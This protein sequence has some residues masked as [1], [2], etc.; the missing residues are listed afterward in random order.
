MAAKKA[1]KAK[2]KA[3]K[4]KPKAPKRETKVSFTRVELQNLLLSL[5]Q[6]NAGGPGTISE[7]QHTAIK[8]S[9]DKFF[10]PEPETV[11]EE[12]PSEEKTNV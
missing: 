7:V 5:A 4:P 12:K 2:P 3:K 9:L 1:S 8:Q 11:S 6:V 10:G